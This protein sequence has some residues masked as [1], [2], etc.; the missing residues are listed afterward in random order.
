VQV[1]IKE[2]AVTMEVKNSGLE[3][4]VYN[5][6]GEHLGDLVITKTKL[7]WCKGKTQRKSGVPVK[8][9]DFIAWMES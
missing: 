3:L 1:S 8:W 6:K 5:S 2:L 7:I 4:D 9:E